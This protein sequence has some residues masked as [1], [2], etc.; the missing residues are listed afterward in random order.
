MMG[1]EGEKIQPVFITIDPERDTP[2]V[3][4][5][6]VE[7][8]GPRLVGLTGSVQEIA[9]VAKAYRVYYAKAQKAGSEDYLMDHSSIVYLI[10]PDG[11]FVK[12]FTY[13]TD[14]AKLASSL[15]EAVTS[16]P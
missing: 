5:A 8:F 7:N 15:K 4:K 6:Y 1:A 9:D 16:F 3:M 13:T 10:G 11:T 14:A 2:E 12:H